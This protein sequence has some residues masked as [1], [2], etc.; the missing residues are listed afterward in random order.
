[1]FSQGSWLDIGVKGGY[2]MDFLINKNIAD[3]DTHEP[4][5]SFGYT[6]GGKVGWNFNEEHA[7]NIDV[8]SSKFG[9][10]Y[11][12]LSIDPVDSSRTAYEK[13]FN[14]T[15]LDF[16]LLYRH[17]KNAGYLEVGPQFSLIKSAAYTSGEGDM[18]GAEAKN[19]LISSYYSAVLGAGGFLGGSENFRITLGFRATYAFDDIISQQGKTNYFPSGNNYDT[20]VK[21][22]P[23]SIMVILELEFD[24]GFLAT[25]N[26]KKSKT[27][28]L[29]FR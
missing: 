29:L 9:I 6:Y 10:S 11:E 23:L 4:Q 20:Y 12:Y 18:S 25:S 22:N 8:M 3:D 21:S 17:V 2:G 27:S 28:F 13:N 19:N 5:F 1:M 24:V 15:A 16:M 26:C 7:V 14:Y